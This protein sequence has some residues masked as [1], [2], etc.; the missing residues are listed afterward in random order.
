[1][2][3]QLLNERTSLESSFKSHVNELESRITRLTTELHQVKTEN[4]TLE[5]ELSRV[6]GERGSTETQHR[7]VVTQLEGEIGFLNS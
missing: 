2:E 3:T 7:L 1:M 4:A 5:S 6:G